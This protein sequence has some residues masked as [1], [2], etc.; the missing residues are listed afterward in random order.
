MISIGIDAGSNTWSGVKLENNK[1][2]D[3]F[4]KNTKDIKNDL[5]KFVNFLTKFI[6]N[7]PTVLPSAFGAKLNLLKNIKKEE[8]KLALLKNTS[9]NTVG[10]YS[11]L[12]KLKNY[13]IDAYLIPSIKM[14]PTVADYKKVNKI[15]MG[16]SDKLCVAVYA[17]KNQSEKLNIDIKKTSF[18]LIEIGSSFTSLIFV[19]EG[20]IIDGLGGT[21]G[22]MGF[23]A[24]G[25]IDGELFSFKKYS[26]NKIYTGGLK[27]IKEDIA[28]DA[29]LN[30]LK[31]NISGIVSTNKVPK[32]IIISHSNQNEIIKEIIEICKTYSKVELL[33]NK[34]RASNAAYGAALLAEDLKTSKDII[35][36]LKINKSKNITDFIY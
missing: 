35:N 23:H 2:S 21:S 3:Y 1:A 5:D 27:D 32:E 24:K 30:S 28:K 11:V 19:D 14:L 34:T 18:L 22:A 16:T 7:N 6:E 33:K 26:K 12:K 31:M 36:Q 10:L 8:L 17:I 29:F 20:K 9:K 25:A 13:N 4:V 15:D